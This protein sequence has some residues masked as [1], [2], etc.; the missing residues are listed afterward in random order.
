MKSTTI[1]ALI[2][3]AQLAVVH[4]VAVKFSLYWEISWLDNLMHLLG[5]VVLVMLLYTLVDIKMIRARWVVSWRRT[6]GLV[7]LVLM[8]WEVLGVVMIMRF[9]ANFIADTSLDVLF[10]ILGSIIGWWIGRQLK[11]LEL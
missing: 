1:L 7:L 10:G 3:G 5:G 2:L 4:W 6:A 9:K 8:G 11:K